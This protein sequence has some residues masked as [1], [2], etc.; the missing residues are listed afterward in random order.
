MRS[1]GA[2]TKVT[3]AARASGQ[4]TLEAWVTPSSLE[5]TGPARIVTVSGGTMAGELNVH[6]GQSAT[7][8]SARLRTTADNFSWVQTAG[9]FRSTS[10]PVHVVVTF[11]GTT[12]RVYVDGVVQSVSHKP[13][14][15][16]SSWDLSYPLVVGNEA[17]LD[18]SWLGTVHLVAAYGRAL[19]A[20]EVR[21][22][23]SA[24]AAG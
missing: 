2:A 5:Q 12:Q 23:F 8:A 3:S 14:G 24:G 1:A 6:L 20:A 11:D 15:D 19:S 21:Q 16:L 17:T 9:A 4:V 13:A 18:R 10:S 7:M 22:N